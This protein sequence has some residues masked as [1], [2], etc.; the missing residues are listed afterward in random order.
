MDLTQERPYDITR[1]AEWIDFLTWLHTE[2]GFDAGA[3]IGVVEKPWHFH[4]EWD[5]YKEQGGADR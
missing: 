5:R 1:D 2:E 4:T 3:I